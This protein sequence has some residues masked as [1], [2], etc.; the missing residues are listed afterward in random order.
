MAQLIVSINVSLDGYIAT[1]G[2]DD[3][4]WL[5]ID[6]EVHRAFNALAAGA[7]AFLYGRKVYEVM[8]P[9]WPDAVDDASKPAYEREYG[10]L[11]VEKPKVVF[12]TTL[13]ET[14]WNT[15]VVQ[16][17]A[18]DEVARLKRETD[19]YLLGYCGSQ[20]ASALQQRGL[21]DEYLLFVHPST[22]GGGLP[23]F[24]GRLDL[25]LLDVRR[26]DNG[27]LA[28]RYAAPAALRESA[29]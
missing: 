29:P 19:R 24:R 14:R 4:S 9:Y 12:S 25:T 28:L 11:W 5:R 27:V 22:V 8:I 3:G 13:R 26:F 2:E 17:A 7:G 16:S 1:Q 6:E 10:R 18:L 15:R 21:I 20:F 23:F